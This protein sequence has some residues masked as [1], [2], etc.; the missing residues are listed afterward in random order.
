MH[1]PSFSMPLL[2]L[3][4]KIGTSEAQVS[5]S[6]VAAHQT[7]QGVV[8]TFDKPMD[9]AGAS[10]VNNYR[11]S[12]HSVGFGGDPVSPDTVYKIKAAQ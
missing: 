9:P 11:V 4:L 2:P 6:I 5:P 3:D 12:S 10:N 1:D 7:R 8:L